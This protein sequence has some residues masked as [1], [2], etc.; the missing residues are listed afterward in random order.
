MGVYKIKNIGN[1]IKEETKEED[2]YLFNKERLLIQDGLS[3]EDEI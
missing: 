3:M 2:Q 1:D